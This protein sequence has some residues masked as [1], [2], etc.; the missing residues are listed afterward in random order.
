MNNYIIKNENGEIITNSAERNIILL[1][2]AAFLNENEGNVNFPV[3]MQMH[4]ATTTAV[5]IPELAGNGTIIAAAPQVTQAK[6]STKTSAIQ[7]AQQG[8]VAGNQKL[9]G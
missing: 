1:R 9:S 5:T 4:Q 8:V 3:Q 7:Q 2:Y 6:K